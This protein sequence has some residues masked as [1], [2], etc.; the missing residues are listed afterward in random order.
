MTKILWFFAF[1]LVTACTM[2]EPTAV[3]QAEAIRQSIEVS[4]YCLYDE[5]CVHVSVQCPFGCD[6][7]V[8][9]AHAQTISDLSAAY[10]SECAQRCAMP[11]PPACVDQRCVAK[12]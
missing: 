3:D 12:S 2:P 5:D 9:R 11:A 4:N 7:Y 6:V 10:V 1:L 8:N